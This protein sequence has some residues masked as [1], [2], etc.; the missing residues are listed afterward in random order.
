MMKQLALTAPPESSGRAAS[1]LCHVVPLLYLNVPLGLYASR[2][3]RF[4]PSHSD[5]KQTENELNKQQR[6]A[7]TNRDHDS[8]NSNN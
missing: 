2:Q 1:V 5:N 7:T 4:A 8:D 6:W 3:P